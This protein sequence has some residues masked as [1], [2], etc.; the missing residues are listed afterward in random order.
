[1]QE[2]LILLLVGLSVWLF[3]RLRTAR[4][5][6]DRLLDVEWHLAQDKEALLRENSLL[7]TDHLK[8]Q[9]QPHTLN[10]ILANLK[11]ISSKLSRGMDALSETLEY[12]LYK[13]RTNLVSVEDECSFIKTYLALNDLFITE[14]DAIVVNVDQ[15]DR[16]SPYYTTE[17]IPHLITAYFIENAFKHGD[18]NHPEFLQIELKLDHA[19][20]Q[21]HV[22]NRI[23]HKPSNK[24]GGIGLLNME[25]RLAHLLK[26]KYQINTSSTHDTYDAILTIQLVP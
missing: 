23:K 1:M 15:V 5:E 20:F 12:I 13:G 9:M 10:N 18:V 11:A 22:S 4:K 16:N 14:L 2:L 7:A 24:V 17:C 25:K 21:I 6:R 3:V 26:G 8:F 19:L